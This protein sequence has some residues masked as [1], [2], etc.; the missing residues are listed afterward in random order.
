[1]ET[2]HV[3]D[4]DFVNLVIISAAAGDAPDM[5][6]ASEY[7]LDELNQSN[8]LYDMSSASGL[9][10]SKY[11]PLALSAFNDSGRRYAVPQAVNVLGLY[12]NSALVSKPPLTT[13]D[14][15]KQVSNGKKIAQI[16]N[17]YYLF[18]W[19]G[20]YNGKLF[21]QNGIC[22]AGQQSWLDAAGFLTQLKSANH[23]FYT[24]DKYDD[25]VDSF[26]NGNSAFLVMGNMEWQNLSDALGSDLAV[27]PLPKA[28]GGTA[29]PFVD[30]HGIAVLASGSQIDEALVAVNFMTSKESSQI[31]MEDGWLVP[32]RS[33]VNSTD[34]NMS[35]FIVS[36]RNGSLLVSSITS[37]NYLNTFDTAWKSILDDGADPE[38]EFTAACRQLDIMNGK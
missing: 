4:P 20:S 28:E 3:A 7:L 27:I 34:P 13:D 6:I 31:Y 16:E 24:D 11:S 8:M 33:D 36:A 19:V 12:Y 14:L 1:M 22:L 29:A 2:T 26:K 38:A 9:D 18:P 30:F 17:S 5:L 15:L 23:G 35:A 21:D 25:A 10:L 32:A 37:L